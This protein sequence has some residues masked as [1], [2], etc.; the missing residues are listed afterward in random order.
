MTQPPKRDQAKLTPR[1]LWVKRYIVGFVIGIWFVM[2]ALYDQ[3]EVAV[4]AFALMLAIF[5]TLYMFVEK[6]RAKG[7]KK[8]HSNEQ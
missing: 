2:T 8:G 3:R 5:T 7:Q 1:Q 6:L 4:V